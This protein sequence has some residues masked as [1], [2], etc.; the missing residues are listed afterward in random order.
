LVGT[1]ACS[2]NWAVDFGESID[3]LEHNYPLQEMH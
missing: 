3:N 2:A 1:A